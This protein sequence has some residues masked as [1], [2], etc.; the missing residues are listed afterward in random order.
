[1]SDSNNIDE[2]SLDYLPNELQYNTQFFN[3]EAEDILNGEASLNKSMLIEFFRGI[4][5]C[6]QANVSKDIKQAG[7]FNYTGVHNDELFTLEFCQQMDFNLVGRKK[8][9]MTIIL[10]GNL[11]RYEELGV[12]TTK[13]LMGHFMTICAVRIQGQQAGVLYMK[14]SIATLKQY[15]IDKESDFQYLNLFEQKFISSGV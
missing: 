4:T 14:G 7:K 12:V 8:K 6:H 10:K 3:S 15:F 11:E 13:A 2:L 1:M 9:L 5:L